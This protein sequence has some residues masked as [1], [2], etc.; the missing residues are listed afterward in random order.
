MKMENKLVEEKNSSRTE[1]FVSQLLNPLTYVLFGAAGISFFLREYGDVLVILLVVV[2]NG[3]MGVIQEGK[4]EQALAALKKMTTPMALVCRNGQVL[5]VSAVSLQ[6][7]D[8]VLLEPGSQVPADL[9]LTD[10]TSLAIEESALTGESFPVQKKIGDAAFMS[11]LVTAGRGK[12]IVTAIGMDTEIGRIAALIQKSKPE[13]TPLQQRLNQLGKA[14]SLLALGLCALLF[15]IA[16]ALGREPAEMLVTAISLAVAAVP[17]GLPAIVTIVLAIGVGRLAHAGTIVRKLPSVET[18]GCVDVVCSDK[19]GTLTQNRMTVSSCFYYEREFPANSPQIPAPLLEG[20][21]LCNNSLLSGKHRLGDPTELA[22]SV[23]AADHGCFRDALEE[24]APRIREVPFS[25]LTK[26]MLTTHRSGSSTYS[27]RKGAPDVI[28]KHCRKQLTPT[29]ASDLTAEAR[30]RLMQSIERLSARGLRLLALARD[31]VFLGIACL[32]DPLR[33]ES[34]PAVR[35]FRRAGIRTVMI[36]GDHP[37]T[38][39]AIAAEL[40]LIDEPQSTQVMTGSELELISD[41][42]LA[43]RVENISVFAR[44]TPTHKVRIVQAL[45]RTG[46]LVAMTGDGVNDAPSLKEADIGVAM[47]GCGT[48]VAKGAADMILTDDNFAT[49]RSAIAGGRSIYENIRKSVLFLLSSN[50]GEIMTMFFCVACNLAVPLKAIHILWVNLITDS[51]PALAL[52]M[53]RNDEDALMSRPPRPQSES[54]MAHGGWFCTCFYGSFIAAISL[55]A[56]LTVPF[57][58]LK[59]LGLPMTLPHLRE[60]L[61]IP[62]LLTQAQTYAFTTLG[63]SQLFHAIGMR[64]ERRSIFSMKLSENPVMILAFFLGLLLQLAVTELPFLVELF[65]TV[66]LAWHEWGYLLALSATPLFVHQILYFAA[67]HLPS[68]HTD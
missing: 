47:G 17:E 24:R 6:P 49:I 5:K 59:Q 37:L 41:E 36:T 42:H 19:T 1:K 50:F 40:T 52:G 28:L 58:Y 34:L 3:I 57:F 32:K 44:V 11:T 54:L 8:E 12:G 20:F 45:Q 68:Q 64:D 16:L 7:G 43:E 4:A 62:S 21:C 27:Y 14:L 15:V 51:L 30:R 2:F 23:W 65:E 61:A 13:P 60:A 53:D 29:G 63:I 9:K 26:E 48:D 56:F 10:T 66:S 33:P 67:G 35:A 55:V 39:A 25:S 46:H 18:L 22:L 31:D 38:A